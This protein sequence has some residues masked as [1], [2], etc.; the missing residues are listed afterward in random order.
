MGGRPVTAMN[1]VGMPADE[2]PLEIINRIF[3]GGADKIAEAGCI[4]VGGHTVKNPEPLYGLSVTG[5]VHP[6]RIISNAEGAV[7]DLLVLTKP[8]GTG[9]ISTAIKRGLADEA[10]AATA[11]TLMATLNTPGHTIGDQQLVRAG[12]D[13]TGFGLLGHLTSLCRESRVTACLEHS[14]L[15]V[16]DPQVLR[17]IEDGCVPGGTKANLEACR[18]TTRFADSVPDVHRLLLADAQTS[19]GLLLAVPP[20]KLDAVLAILSEADTP[21]AVT[22]GELTTQGEALVEVS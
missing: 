2:L 15:P 5:L 4:L 17:F 11:A 21:C 6:E 7:G 20:A 13:V 22:I 9:I 3:Q 16:I 12:T 18:D 8:L 19:G 14:A 1:I 10:L